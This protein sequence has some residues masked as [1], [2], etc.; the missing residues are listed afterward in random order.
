MKYPHQP[1]LIH[2]VVRYLVT[3][4]DGLY[5]DGTVG[6]GGH[7]EAIGRKVTAQGRLICLDRDP[8]AIRISRER[9]SPL[10]ERVTLARANYAELNGVLQDLRF[11]EVNGVFLDLGMS[12]YQLEYSRRGFSFSRDEPLDMRMD[13]DDELSAYQLVNNLSRRDLERILRNYGEE[14]MARSIAKSIDRERRKKPID[15]SLRLANLIQSVVPRSHHPGA[16]HPAT[17]TFQAIRIAVNR[18]LENLDEFLDKMPSLISKG[19]RLVI[20]TYHSLEDRMV[21]KAIIDWEKGCSCP[22]DLPRCA[23]GKKPLF[24]RL[25]KRAIKPDQQEV[26]DN[27]RARSAILRAAERI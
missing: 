24:K 4:S 13:P 16:K 27:P 21:K 20:L 17:R 19:G 14:K 26:E 5:V 25:H 9:L 1:V 7:S 18:E 2:E 3:L 23:C 10:R 12:S 22:P 6:C 11:K 8:E 15:S